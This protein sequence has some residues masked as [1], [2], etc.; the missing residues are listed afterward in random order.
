MATLYYAEHVHISQ[1]PTRIPTSYFRM[2]QESESES[3]QESV[4]GNV[5][6]PLLLANAEQSRTKHLRTNCV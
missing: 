5:N 1:T 3:V 2:E 4:Y 6:K